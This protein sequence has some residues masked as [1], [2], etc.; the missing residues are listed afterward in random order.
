MT[1]DGNNWPSA[2]VDAPLLMEPAPIIKPV[3]RRERGLARLGGPDLEKKRE[4]DAWLRG[5]ATATAT[6][7]REQRG[8]GLR[9]LV[10]ASGFSHQDMVDAGTSEYDLQPLRE[11][12]GGKW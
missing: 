8:T 6:A 10:S 12:M 5:W 7:Y 3:Q 2:Y 4:D 1:R 11:L 9:R